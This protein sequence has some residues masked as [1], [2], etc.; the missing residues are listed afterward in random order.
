MPEANTLWMGVG[1]GAVDQY[2]TVTNK[3][4]RQQ[5]KEIIEVPDAAAVQHQGVVPGLAAS[6]APWK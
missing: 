1:R 4:D 6:R 5:Q 3:G 2:A